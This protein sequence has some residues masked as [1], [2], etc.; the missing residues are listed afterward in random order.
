LRQYSFLYI[1]DNKNKKAKIMKTRAD[2]AGYISVEETAKRLGCSL[3]TARNYARLGTLP[4]KKAFNKYYILESAV[5]AYFNDLPK[6][7]LE[8][9]TE[10]I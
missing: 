7:I 3:P 6:P 2:I 9:D 8:N 1:C 10:S 5:T 4:A